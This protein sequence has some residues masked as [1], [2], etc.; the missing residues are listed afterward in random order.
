MAAIYPFTPYKSRAGSP[1]A[2]TELHQTETEM[3]LTFTKEER[4][5]WDFVRSVYH[6][7]F[8]TAETESFGSRFKNRK[9]F[10]NL[11][12]LLSEKVS[13]HE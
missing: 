11:Y 9:T 7:N 13:V 6:V 2:P 10:R 3:P 4:T 1:P 8:R 12:S 5:D